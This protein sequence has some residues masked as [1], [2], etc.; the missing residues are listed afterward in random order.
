MDEKSNMILQQHR[1]L[2]EGYEMQLRQE[3][4]L[5][6]K[7]KLLETQLMDV[8][9]IA[10]KE[11]RTLEKMRKSGLKTWV[12]RNFSS[13][14][15]KLQ[16]QE[17]EVKRA[18][19]EVEEEQEKL[20]SMEQRI[21]EIQAKKREYW[22]HDK[23]YQFLYEQK[24]Q[25]LLALDGSTKEA[26]HTYEAQ[27]EFHKTMIKELNEA[28]RVGRRVKSELERM[29]NSLDSAHSY[30]TW[31]MLGGGLLATA[32][33]HSHLNDAKSCR[34]NVEHL[35]KDF[36]RELSD[37]RLSLE[38]T[39]KTDGFAKFADYWLDDLFSDWKMQNRIN[40]ATRS[41]D[42]AKDKVTEILRKLERGIEKENALFTKCKEE[43]EQFIVEK[44]INES[45]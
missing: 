26:I 36:N 1:E 32:A 9:Y 44:E 5:K 22:D 31:D 37:V 45:N 21:D 4:Q 17:Q 11:Q 29:E 23:K 39:M 41:V 28:I 8:E 24:R 10:R 15:E 30:G 6:A 35:L 3:A 18:K 34:E 16:K 19:E 40:E 12:I 20:V 38:L 13:Y 42:E 2:K 14:Q 7:K 43:M 25:Q 27:I 33:K